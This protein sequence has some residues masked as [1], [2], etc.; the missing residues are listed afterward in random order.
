MT[1]NTPFITRDERVSLP[2]WALAF[3]A[4]P[5]RTT[6]PRCA[7][8][9]PK[10]RATNKTEARDVGAQP[11]RPCRPRPPRHQCPCSGPFLFPAGAFGGF[12][13]EHSTISRRSD[14]RRLFCLPLVQCGAVRELTSL[15]QG[16]SPPAET[17]RAVLFSSG[18]FA[19]YGYFAPELPDEVSIELEYTTDTGQNWSENVYDVFT[20]EAHHRAFSAVIFCKEIQ[21]EH[22]RQRLL[23][24]IASW[25]LA[26]HPE[27]D[28]VRLCIQSRTQPTMAEFR[29]GAR[30]A[31]KDDFQVLY[32]RRPTESL[33]AYEIAT[34]DR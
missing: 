22:L 26:R 27:A 1:E 8:R 14:R 15:L 20:A 34:S 4:P 31:W 28:H 24:S 21:D 25:A 17:V 32:H 9:S 23:S 5:R 30:P 3:S 11:S 7:P 2:S 13:H 19:T 6:F 10:A 12:A 18:A 33:P 29:A 16:D